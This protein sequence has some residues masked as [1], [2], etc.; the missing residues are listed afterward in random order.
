[1]VLFTTTI[2][3]LDSDGGVVMISQALIIKDNRI[4]MVKQYVERGDIV[5]NYPGGSIEVNESPE[6][7]CIRE[8]REETGYEV[9][10]SRLLFKNV[11]YQ[12]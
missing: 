3:N 2:L 9:E 4:L 1:M 10:I 6:Q 5:W 12:P 11:S 8:V 7:A